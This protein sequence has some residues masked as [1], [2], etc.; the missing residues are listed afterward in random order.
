M[1]PRH[2]NLLAADVDLHLELANTGYAALLLSNKGARVSCA[3]AGTKKSLQ[4]LLVDLV[5]VVNEIPDL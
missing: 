1:D 3:I 4:D 2:V 5:A